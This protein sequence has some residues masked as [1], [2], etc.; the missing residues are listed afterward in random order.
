MQIR[1][2]IKEAFDKRQT[3]LAKAKAEETSCF[4]LFCGKKEGIDGVLI[5]IFG[6]VAI[7]QLYERQQSLDTQQLIEIA[8]AIA[9]FTDIRSVYLKSFLVDRSQSL[10]D[11][12]MYAT[13][14]LWGKSAAEEFLVQENKLKFWIRPYSG[15]SVGLFLDQ[16]ENRKYLARTL[17]PQRVLNCF[18]YTCGFS[19]FA[20][21]E[22]AKTTNVDAS[23]KYL[24]WGKRNFQINQ[25]PLD[26]HRFVVEDVCDYL[27][28]AGARGEK[29]DLVI[30]DAPTFGR[31]GK[32]VFSLESDLE[33]LIALAREVMDS[34]GHLF[35]SCNHREYST[36]KICDTASRALFQRAGFE[37]L[38]AVAEDFIDSGNPLAACLI[39]NK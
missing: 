27:R 19:V 28:R 14:P 39:S 2:A 7:L 1:A 29:F 37:S 38:P 20:A 8:T 24:D 34:E 35:L 13:K 10:A 25:L 17:K 23:K 21:S 16:R 3:F 5:D 6:D 18:S 36:D 12:A 22:G 15:F 31:A 4:R 26:G 32:K 33:S 30:V 9:E 11:Q